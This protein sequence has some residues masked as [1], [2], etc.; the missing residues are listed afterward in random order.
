MSLTGRDHA[1]QVT[2]Q[3]A[4]SF[5]LGPTA[6]AALAFEDAD[7]HA[8][9]GVHDPAD[10]P[11]L[12][13]APAPEFVIGFGAR[14]FSADEVHGSLPKTGNPIHLNMSESSTMSLWL[15]DQ[16][17]VMIEISGARRFTSARGAKTFSS[18]PTSPAD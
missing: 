5:V 11:G 1:N 16:V 13:A 14:Q 4:L 15:F 3:R 17:H 7:R 18:P 12:S 9:P 6:L 8:I 10:Q 2:R